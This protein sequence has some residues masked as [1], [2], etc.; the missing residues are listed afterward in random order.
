MRVLGVITEGVQRGPEGV[1]ADLAGQVSRDIEAVEIPAVLVPVFQGGLDG[2]GVLDQVGFDDGVDV[3]GLDDP[4]ADEPRGDQA[5]PRPARM[6][7]RWVTPMG[8]PHWIESMYALGARMSASMPN[9]WGCSSRLQSYIL[10]RGV[11]GPG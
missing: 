10:N 7:R 2:A 5:D 11:R 8:P 9:V 1:R 6:C 3:A 4:A